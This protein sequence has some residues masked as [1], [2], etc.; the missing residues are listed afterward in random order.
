MR[1]GV[2]EMNVGFC[3]PHLSF[4]SKSSNFPFVLASSEE[5]QNRHI[6]NGSLSPGMT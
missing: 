4:L 6:L 3:I 5:R 2:H 1:E